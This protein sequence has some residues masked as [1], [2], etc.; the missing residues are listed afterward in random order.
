M[1]PHRQPH[2]SSKGF[3]GAL[4]PAAARN[5]YHAF[6]QALEPD[7]N[8]DD[9]TRMDQEWIKQCTTLTGIDDFGMLQAPNVKVLLGLIG[10]LS[11]T[12]L[13]LLALAGT[14]GGLYCFAVFLAVFFILPC[15]FA[16]FQ[17]R[18]YFAA[19]RDYRRRRAEALAARGQ[20]DSRPLPVI[21]RPVWVGA[22]IQDA[23]V[24]L[25]RLDA[26]Y[27]EGEVQEAKYQLIRAIYLEHAPAGEQ[28]AAD[29]WGGGDWQ[30][31]R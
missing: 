9:I 10:G 4:I 28:A 1:E 13:A 7:P 6:Q 14:N 2:S 16:L 19:E 20:S 8:A 27:R 26:A 25:A 5:H 24:A 15:S 29:Q 12:T 31:H 18:K 22:G 11:A 21:E 23:R 3:F 30:R 17:T